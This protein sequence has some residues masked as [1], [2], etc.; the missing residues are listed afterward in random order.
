M[1]REWEDGRCV[2]RRGKARTR[3][4]PSPGDTRGGPSKHLEN[5]ARHRYR[6]QTRSEAPSCARQDGRHQRLTERQ[7]AGRCKR[8]GARAWWELAPRNAWLATPTSETAQH[9]GAGQRRVGTAPAT[10]QGAVGREKRR[11]ARAPRHRCIP[12]AP[13]TRMCTSHAANKPDA[14]AGPHPRGTFPTE[15][16]PPPHTRAEGSAFGRWLTAEGMMVFW[17]QSVALAAPVGTWCHTH[18]HKSHNFSTC[19]SHLRFLRKDEN[20]RHVVPSPDAPPPGE[21]NRPTG[22]R[23]H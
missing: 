15:K 18:V 17:G 23:T 9:A 19:Q 22:P 10:S 12:W 13:S 5:A 11:A 2:D 7:R 4:C 14:T 6:N 1:N 16:V 8:A 21:R 3:T 20:R